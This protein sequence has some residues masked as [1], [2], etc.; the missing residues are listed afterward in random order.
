MYRESSTDSYHDRSDDE[1]DLP[2][3][4]DSWNDDDDSLECSR[5]GNPLPKILNDESEINSIKCSGYLPETENSNPG[6]LL[7]QK[8]VRGESLD[9]HYLH[10]LASSGERWQFQKCSYRPPHLLRCDSNMFSQSYLVP[11]QVP[12]N[13]IEDRGDEIVGNLKELELLDI[14]NSVLNEIDGGEHGDH[15]SKK[16]RINSHNNLLKSVE[17]IEIIS[18][19]RKKCHE[20]DEEK[21]SHFTNWDL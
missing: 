11:V 12:N 1:D 10:Q 16:S 21:F 7:S 13:S 18:Q 5:P 9:G 15:R 20:V 17:N 19:K 8:R 4:M 6:S 3:D 2:F 14:Q